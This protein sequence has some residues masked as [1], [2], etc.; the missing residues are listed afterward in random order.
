MKPMTTIT[1]LL[2]VLFFCRSTLAGSVSRSQFTSEVVD[3]EPVDRVQIITTSAR[4]VTYFT[5]LSEL[6]NQEVTHQWLLDDTVIFEKKF[7]VGGPRWRVW[8]SKTVRP[9]MTGTWR[10]NTLDSSGNRI[11]SERLVVERPED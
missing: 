1:G 11:L 5:E 9:G 8:S 6:Q 3:R 4:E 10:V 2:I 7:A